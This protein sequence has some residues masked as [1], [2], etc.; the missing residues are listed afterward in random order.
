MFPTLYHLSCGDQVA[1]V[2]CKRLLK[3]QFSLTNAWIRGTPEDGVEAYS[4]F[5]KIETKIG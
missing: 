2:Y 3:M 4:T 1:V 5:I